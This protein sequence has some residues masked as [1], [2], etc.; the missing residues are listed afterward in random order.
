MEKLNAIVEFIDG[1]GLDEFKKD[2]AACE[3]GN[4][5]A[6]KR[7]RKTTSMLTK[8]FKEFRAESVANEKK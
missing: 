1:G 7:A 2:L 6:G 5:S 3:K 8:L 4:K